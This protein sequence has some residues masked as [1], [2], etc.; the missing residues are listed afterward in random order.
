[1]ETPQWCPKCVWYLRDKIRG[2]A[3]FFWHLL[4]EMELQE[5]TEEENP[6]HSFMG[7]LDGGNDRKK[8]PFSFIWWVCV[9][10]S[11]GFPS[12]VEIRKVWRDFGDLIQGHGMVWVGRSLKT[13][14]FQSPSACKNQLWPKLWGSSP[15]PYLG[16]VSFSTKEIYPGFP[17]GL[18][19][20]LGRRNCWKFRK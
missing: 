4:L 7:L 8:K 13:T 19:S 9:K 10:L 6:S 18:C 11:S 3:Q 1:M 15:F 5:S 2:V 12:M 20:V 14:Q 17:A 16:I